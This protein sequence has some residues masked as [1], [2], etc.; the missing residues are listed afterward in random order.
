MFQG[1][2]LVLADIQER[3][4]R[5]VDHHALSPDLFA[6]PEQ[7]AVL[8]I[9]MSTDPQAEDVVRSRG[10]FNI[11]FRY[12]ARDSVTMACSVHEIYGECVF[13][14]VLVRET[15]YGYIDMGFGV[16]LSE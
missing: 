10:C 7:L 11:T 16:L 15:A 3:I 8:D 5:V 1:F 12:T 6:D 4:S 9:Y 2:K 14:V 13:R